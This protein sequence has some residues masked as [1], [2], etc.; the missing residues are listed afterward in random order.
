MTD[1][2]TRLRGYISLPDGKTLV[3]P[4][5]GAG[6]SHHAGLPLFG[7]LAHRLSDALS[8]ISPDAGEYQQRLVDDGVPIYERM[9][10]IRNELQDARFRQLVVELLSS[11][12][13]EKLD[14]H[15]AIA[16]F[17][18]AI[19]ITTNLDRTLEIACDLVGQ[20]WVH[21]LPPNFAPPQTASTHEQNITRIVKIHGDIEFPDTWVLTSSAYRR[22]YLG[23]TP[24]IEAIQRYTRSKI[25]VFAG[26]S[27]ADTD[28]IHAIAQLATEEWQ[29]QG[30]HFIFAS[31][32]DYTSGLR[33]RVNQIHAFPVLYDPGNSHAELREKLLELFTSP[34]EPHDPYLNWSK[35]ILSRIERVI[36]GPEGK[37]LLLLRGKPFLVY[38]VLATAR[39]R[40]NGPLVRLDMRLREA[41]DA[42]YR[43]QPEITISLGN[44]APSG[45]EEHVISLPPHSP[46]RRAIVAVAADKVMQEWILWRE[47]MLQKLSEDLSG[48]VPDPKAAV[49]TA[50][51][52]WGDPRTQADDLRAGEV[53]LDLA[54]RFINDH[55]EA[56]LGKT[57]A[58]LAARRFRTAGD[59]RQEVRAILTQARADSRMGRSQEAK[60][61]ITTLRAAFRRFA[62]EPDADMPGNLRLQIELLQQEATT[63]RLAGRLDD[64]QEAI[65]LALQRGQQLVATTGSVDD[66]ILHLTSRQEHARLLLAQ[67]RFVNGVGEFRALV[68]DAERL[69]QRALDQGDQRN[70][71]RARWHRIIALGLTI[72][73][74]IDAG[75]RD[76]ARAAH[77]QLVAIDLAPV[78]AAPVMQAYI[79]LWTGMVLEIDGAQNAAHAAY[80]Q[81]ERLFRPLSDQLGL[82]QARHL[83]TALDARLHPEAWVDV[84][85]EL[86][87]VNV[88]AAEAGLAQQALESLLACARAL[89]ASQRV[90]QAIQVANEI[91]QLVE[92]RNRR[93]TAFTREISTLH[94]ALLG[95]IALD[96]RDFSTARRHLQAAVQAA[97]RADF[98]PVRLAEIVRALAQV[99]RMVGQVTTAHKHYSKVLDYSRLGGA[100]SMEAQALT[101]L[102][103]LLRY[104]GHLAAALTHVQA[105]MHTLARERSFVSERA[106]DPS[107]EPLL[108]LEGDA[109]LGAIHVLSQMGMLDQADT[110]ARELTQR[111][112]MVA[113][114]PA[115][116]GKAHLA[117]ADIAFQ[118]LDRLKQPINA[119][120]VEPLAATLEKGIDLCLRHGATSHG[121]QAI[122]VLVGLYLELARTDATRAEVGIQ[123]ALAYLTHYETGDWADALMSNAEAAFHLAMSAF[124]VA[125]V[126]NLP[127]KMKSAVASARTQLEALHNSPLLAPLLAG[128]A[129]FL[130]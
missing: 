22:T 43:H 99:E 51:Q 42:A 85:A 65:D 36:Q 18:P 39:D 67:S 68:K 78:S 75:L 71:G 81:A 52:L 56:K 86:R 82:I 111:Q 88:V 109:Q 100:R 59:K 105:A 33:D 101:A 103:E 72:T 34:A 23:R 40:M 6:L 87:E 12:Q 123:A 15:R 90:D 128:P 61:A 47:A 116:V 126:Q 21:I 44:G 53:A 13:K 29:T 96:R 94:L 110:R 74:A 5:L 11:P 38:S 27:L 83:R 108:K 120:N 32:P 112:D 125:M 73:A 84:L 98:P 2:W 91:E 49:R 8:E 60:Q 19:V 92:K 17:H 102:A 70:L 10:R 7:E 48:P 115:A 55:V 69:E 121:G 124:D 30:G 79:Q 20:P 119:T 80:A 113:A 107:L 50:E 129:S 16:Q 89:L 118:R 130:T 57:Y 58:D 77:V 122:R 26:Y 31:R 127:D 45:T 62:E 95:E 114:A 97:T 106:G 25:L 35:D 117:L 64:S 93:K 1:A 76:D 28:V 66:E 4:V 46:H 41:V 3:V 24:Y 37:K 14:V 54:S 63:L 104:Q 9:E